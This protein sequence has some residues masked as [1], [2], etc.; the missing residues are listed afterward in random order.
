MKFEFPNKDMWRLVRWVQR[1]A[2]KDTV[3]NRVL[4][5]IHTK[6]GVVTEAT[7]RHRIHAV[8]G[9]ISDFPVGLV[10]FARRVTYSKPNEYEV[11]DTELDYPDLSNVLLPGNEPVADFIF[12]RGYLADALAMPVDPHED[13]RMTVYAVGRATVMVITDRHDRFRAVVAGK[14]AE[15]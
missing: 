2:R 1:A 3:Y 8:L 7:D 4:T 6:S 15:E 10:R 14:I 11:G 5:Y 13:L 9:G 12:D